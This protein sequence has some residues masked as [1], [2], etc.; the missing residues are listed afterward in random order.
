MPS[1]MSINGSATTRIK[2]LEAGETAAVMVVEA[3]VVVEAVEE[4][5]TPTLTLRISL[6]RIKNLNPLVLEQ[7]WQQ[8][9]QKSPAVSLL[10]PMS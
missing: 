5:A 6:K 3:G 1:T 4:V 10:P 8:H 9:S 7:P 2:D